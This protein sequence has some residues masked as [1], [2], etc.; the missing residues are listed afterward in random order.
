MQLAPSNWYHMTNKLQG[1][2]SLARTWS[3][4]RHLLDPTK[5]KN[6]TSQTLRKIVHKFKG[7]NE[8][9]L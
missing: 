8:E 3:L 5:S 2:L 7:T 4:I 6:H 1:T 9:I